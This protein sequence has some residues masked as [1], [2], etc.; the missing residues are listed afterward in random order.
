[1][2]IFS[3]KRYLKHFQRSKSTFFA[4]LT[5]IASA[6]SAFA[7]SN[8]DLFR[9]TWQVETPDD[10]ALILIVKRSGLASYFWGDNTD[11]TVYQGSW[12]ATDEIA[13]LQWP[14]GTQHHITRDALGF[15]IS[16]M[17]AN[18]QV[19]YTVPAQQ[20]PKEVLGQWAKPPS[21]ANQVASARD[22]AKGF[23]GVWQIGKS[24]GNHYI[25]VEADRS[26]ASNIGGNRGTRGSWAK[27][28]SELHIVWDSGQYSILRENERAFAFKWIESGVVI[29]DD[30]TEF[31]PATRTIEDKVPATWLSGY[32]AEREVRTGGI[33]FSSR[34]NARIFYR[35]TWL[36]RLAEKS[37][38]RIE[39]G[40]FGGLTTSLDRKN[41]GSWRMDGQDI[42]MRWDNGQ[43]RILSPV[44]DG[45]VLYEFKPGRPLDG[46]PTRALQAAPADASK[47]AQH[48]KGREDVARQMLALAEAAGID[49]TEQEAGWGR[50][51]AR[52]AWPFGEDDSATTAALLAQGYEEAT[53]SDPWWWPFW[54][55]SQKDSATPAEDS[56]ETTESETA[57]NETAAVAPVAVSDDNTESVDKAVEADSNKVKKKASKKDW[58]WPF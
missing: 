55:E 4:L 36:I 25:F 41:E 28:G 23:F 32:K 56:S 42:F 21:K 45:F 19:N 14:D 17:G 39:V 33:A 46:V 34:K 48:L 52:W 37:Y 3:K 9:G 13:T 35:G 8:S 53:E 58:A 5:L 47:L 26:A 10:G 18:Q 22:K 15:G 24:T 49:P 27:Q 6:T 57:S 20:V 51:F 54:S 50:T 30:E 1:M 40:R 31:V 11:R 2:N 7:Q 43:R 12:T 16:H 38:E 29:E 44:G